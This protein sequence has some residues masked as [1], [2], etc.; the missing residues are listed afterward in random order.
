MRT[1]GRAAVAG[2]SIAAVEMARRAAA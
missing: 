1:G 2:S